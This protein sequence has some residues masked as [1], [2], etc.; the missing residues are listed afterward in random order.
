MTAPTDIWLELAGAPPIDR[1]RF[2]RPR[3]DD[4]EYGALAELIGASS[5]VDDIP[6][7]PSGTMLREEWEDDPDTFVPGSD[8]IVA[9]VDGRRGARPVRRQGVRGRAALDDLRVDPRVTAAH[10]VS[11]AYAAG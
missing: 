6:W 9:E 11:G 1:L 10:G 3:P 2:R 4:A 5:R 8:R 7:L